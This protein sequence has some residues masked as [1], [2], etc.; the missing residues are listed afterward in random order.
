MSCICIEFQAAADAVVRLDVQYRMKLETNNW[1][2]RIGFMSEYFNNINNNH[3]IVL[4][5]NGFFISPT[6]IVTSR[7]IMYSY[8]CRVY[9]EK[10]NEKIWFTI[11]NNFEYL[12]KCSQ[13]FIGNT[14]INRNNVTIN[15]LL[16][17]NLDI[18]GF[19]FSH[20]WDLGAS[21]GNSGK[22]LIVDDQIG[23]IT[24]PTTHSTNDNQYLEATNCQVGDEVILMGYF[25][26]DKSVEQFYNNESM[27]ED[28]RDHM[29]NCWSTPNSL[30]AVKGIITQI[31]CNEKN[32]Y[33]M[34]V[35]EI[36]G[37]QPSHYF[38]KGGPILLANKKNK[39]CGVNIGNKRNVYQSVDVNN[40]S[41]YGWTEIIL[42]VCSNYPLLHTVN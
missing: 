21:H 25:T 41:Y 36:S 12:N 13:Q 16:L 11:E 33:Q 26:N 42:G 4:N 19:H 6:T 40:D 7:N 10:Y 14:T 5:G 38:T 2:Q 32:N 35:K 37:K 27:T 8:I 22:S 29:S 39:Y 17:H 23:L 9:F 30:T 20:S 15:K 24:I 28:I 18:K 31:N 3:E 34:F 1:W